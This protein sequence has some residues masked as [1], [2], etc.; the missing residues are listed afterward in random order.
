MAQWE[1]LF[2]TDEDARTLLHGLIEQVRGEPNLSIL[3]G[4][5][6]VAAKGYVGNFEI[7]IRQQPRG[8]ADNFQTVDQA[9]AAC[10]VEVPDEFN[11]GLT[12][13]K[14]IYRPYAGCYPAS[15]VIDREH[16]NQCQ[17]CL[18]V[19]RNSGIRLDE[20]PVRD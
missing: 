12:K 4:A 11:F 19:N 1:H 14:A 13:R 2:P 10:P 7:R 6:V 20:P 17:E 15:P 3:T 5:E 8:V 18:K 16:C 9:I